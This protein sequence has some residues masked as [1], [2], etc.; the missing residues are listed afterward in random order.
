MEKRL[1]GKTPQGNGSTTAGM[2]KENAK[3]MSLVELNKLANE[4]PEIYAKLFN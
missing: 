1:A 3:K 4:Q 2:T